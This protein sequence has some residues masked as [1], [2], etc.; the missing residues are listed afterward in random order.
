LF[1]LFVKL[2][3]PNFDLTLLLLR[4]LLLPFLEL[5]VIT[6][7]SCS[8]L[9]EIGASVSHSFAFVLLSKFIVEL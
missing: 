1:G 5:L 9:H 6:V 2:L 8:D 4:E 7:L 3:E